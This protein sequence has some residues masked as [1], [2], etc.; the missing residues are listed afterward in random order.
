MA[1]DSVGTGGYCC[2]KR[3]E[4]VKKKHILNNKGLLHV[5]KCAAAP[6]RR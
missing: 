4:A 1:T 6:I 3:K 5:M 2:K